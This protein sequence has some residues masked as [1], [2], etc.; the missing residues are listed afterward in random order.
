M[1][2]L[3]AP[4]FVVVDSAMAQ[5]ATK[6]L[7]PEALTGT[8]NSALPKGFESVTLIDDPTKVGEVVIQRIRLPTHALVPPHTHP[9]AD[10]IT[11]ISGSVGFGLSD[12]VETSGKMLRADGFFTH[13]GKD[14][15][16]VWTHDEGAIV[17]IHFIAP[18][19]IDYIDPAEDPRKK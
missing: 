7:A 16:Y 2:A 14:S 17:Q 13:P 18:G 10:T 12:K 9:F 6:T 3:L 15:H 5:N 4:T 8:N 1:V 19:G 11:V